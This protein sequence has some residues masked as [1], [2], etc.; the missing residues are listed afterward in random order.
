[1][2]RAQTAKTRLDWLLDSPPEY[3]WQRLDDWLQVAT[4]GEVRRHWPKV[5]RLFSGRMPMPAWARQE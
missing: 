4:S 1:M 2:S 3:R 5:G